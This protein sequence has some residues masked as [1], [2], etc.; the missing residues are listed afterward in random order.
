MTNI[1]CVSGYWQITNKHNNN[2]LKWFN[3]S[4]KVNCPYVFFSNKQGIELIKKYRGVLPT[5]YIECE[6]ADFYTWKYREKMIAHP[7]HCPSIELN[8]IWNEKIFLLQKASELNPFRSEWFHW[9]DSG[10]C[11]YRD[12]PPKNIP[13][14]RIELPINKFIYCSSNPYYPEA[15]TRTSYYHHISGT[16]LLHVS[17]VS[18]I[19]DLYKTYLDKLVDKNNIWTDQVILTHIFKDHSDIF[20][21]LCDGYGEISRLLFG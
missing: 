3:N 1:T 16:Y 8:L 7:K 11:I 20:L 17:M 21:C 14:P 12:T 4:L 9:I 15:V 2:Y 10:M 18:T 13:M 5:Y 6:I 19:V